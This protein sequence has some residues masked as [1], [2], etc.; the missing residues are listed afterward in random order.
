VT[1]A[2]RS[3]SPEFVE[4]RRRLAAAIR[5][6]PV[7]KASGGAACAVLFSTPTAVRN[8]DVEHHYRADADLAWLTGFFEPDVVF[9]LRVDDDGER[10]EVFLRPRDKKAEIWNGRRLGAE[11]APAALAVDAAHPIGDLAKELP[12]LLWDCG[13]VLTRLGRRHKDDGALLSAMRLTT[14][15]TR[16][17]GIAPTTVV[18][19]GP[20]IGQLRWKKDEAEIA[21]MEA[22]ARAAMAGHRRA[23]G[24]CRPGITERDLEAELTYSFLTEGGSGHAYGPIVAAGENACIL[25]YEENDA[26][27]RDGDLVL[28]D[29]GAEVACYAA[30]IT[31]TFPASGR[32]TG[33]Q[34]DLYEIVLKANEEAIAGARPGASLRALDDVARRVLTE[35]LVALKLL[36]GDV[37]ELMTR[38]PE[39]GDPP[40]SAGTCALDRFYMHGTGHYLGLDVHDAGPYHALGEP[41]PFEPGV[42]FTVE[43]GLYVAPD[44]EE[45]PEA[46][47]GIGIRIEDDVL[48]TEGG[49]RVLT[50][51]LEKSVE[52]IEQLVG[53]DR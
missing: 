16:R 4:R 41:T 15:R 49:A 7:V 25:H 28:I 1:D 10:A 38:Q 26:P 19:L 14:A 53:R 45:A 43:P 44:D 5:A 48:I 50:G 31:R 23:M 52:G 40:W 18:D 39:E 33:P 20:L 36:E 27:V 9:V 30:D 42:A 24:R 8:H 46:F 6:D 29:A 2:P 3:L 17:R 34:K 21:H 37:E 51:D 12:R 47:R 13:T 35:G 11:R 22:A 32:F